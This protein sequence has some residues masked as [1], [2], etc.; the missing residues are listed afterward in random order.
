[1]S[2]FDFPKAKDCINLTVKRST[3][4]MDTVKCISWMYSLSAFNNA[5]FFTSRLKDIKDVTYMRFQFGR[6]EMFYIRSLV[7]LLQLS[8]EV[9]RN[10]NHCECYRSCYSSICKS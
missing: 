1:M 3:F 10:E 5:I 9:S 2:N 7:N 6:S 4:S 8:P